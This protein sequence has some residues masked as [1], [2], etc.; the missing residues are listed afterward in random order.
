[1]FCSNDREAI[2]A[3]VRWLAAIENNIDAQIALENLAVALEEN[4]YRNGNH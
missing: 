2:I 4:K 3:Y 1:M